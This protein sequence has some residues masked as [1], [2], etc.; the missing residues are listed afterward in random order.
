MDACSAANCDILIT[1]AN[2]RRDVIPSPPSFTSAWKY[3]LGVSFGN[4]NY[5]LIAAVMSLSID[6]SSPI[7]VASVVN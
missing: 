2:H 1:G 7:V 4:L 5:F 3:A 6:L